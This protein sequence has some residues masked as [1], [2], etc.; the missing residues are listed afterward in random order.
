MPNWC[1]NK[2]S[3]SGAEADIAALKA[4]VTSEDSVFDFQKIVPMPALLRHTC[5]GSRSFEVDGETVTLNTWYVDDP[6]NILDDGARPF[7]EAEQA[8][9]DAIGYDSWYEWCLAHWGCKWNAKDAEIIEDCSYQGEPET[10][11]TWTFDTPWAP[12]IPV[13]EVL[14]SRFPYLHIVGFYNEPGVMAAGYY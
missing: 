10:H 6:V 14:K 1:M 2:I 7:T 4:L 11:I 8:E 13:I 3:A 12:P 5:S 9:L